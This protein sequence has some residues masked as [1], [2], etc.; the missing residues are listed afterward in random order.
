M[1]RKNTFFYGALLCTM[2]FLILV[3]TGCGSSA[4][5]GSAG[6]RD[7]TDGDGSILPTPTATPTPL[8]PSMLTKFVDPLPIPPIK[9]PTSAT[10]TPFYQVTMRQTYQKA[11]RDL[12]Y[13]RCWGYDGMWPGPTFVV[14]K[15]RPIQV[16]WIN[17]LPSTH[18]LPVDTTLMAAALP[19]PQV[20][21]VVHLHGGH[22]PPNSDG[23]PDAW[24]SPGFSQTGSDFTTQIYD[25]PNDQQGATLWYHDQAHGITHLNI[26][27]GLAGFY[28]I[29][30]PADPN[31]QLPALEYNIGLALQDRMFFTDGS[32]NYP[33]D[34]ANTMGA[35]IF[36]CIHPEF[37]G[38]TITVNGKAWPFL[39]VEPRKYRFRILG[40]SNARFYHLR[41]SNGQLFIIIGSDGGLLPAP[42]TQGDLLIAP[43]ERYDVIIDFAR[44]TGE[45]FTMTNDAPAPYPGGDSDH[46]DAN[47]MQIMQFRVVKPLNY[48]VNDPAIPAVLRPITPLS[49]TGASVRDVVLQ[50][51]LDQY[52]RLMHTLN[53]KSSTD[54]IDDKPTLGST[55]VWRFINTTEDTHPMHLHLVQFQILDRRPYDMEHFI[56]T[57]DP[58]TG[59]GGE[60]DFT[61]PAQPPEAY[62]N[63]WKD[64]VTC[65][66]GM[67]TR[68]ITKFD[69]PLSWANRA[70]PG[71]DGRYVSQ[72]AIPE[73][74]EHDMMRQFQVVP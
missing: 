1:K 72:C 32:F 69:A 38:D 17:E 14:T 24:F 15:D 56:A 65:P 52:G 57:A 16:K 18:I 28:F 2:G 61:G 36:P 23:K 66:P 10:G 26:T 64:T 5:S 9:Q 47:T 39:E 7:F 19:A 67:V 37:F 48:S 40:G 25:Y 20:R 29:M 49:E 13:T 27:A 35:P 42:V 11:H 34:P 51:G 6:I 45:K 68:I 43:G 73:N 70:T 55:E 41:L 33:A 58:V 12:P 8:D 31:S 3:L 59:T 46:L 63:G 60:I 44:H 22:T 50:D 62:E 4:G 53:G 54:G 21:N 74:E 71:N 30:D